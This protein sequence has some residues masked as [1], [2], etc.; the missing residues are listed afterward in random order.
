MRVW[1]SVRMSFLLLFSASSIGVLAGPA[2][3]F[4]FVVQVLKD[5]FTKVVLWEDKKTAL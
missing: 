2:L 1:M 4:L 5:V 3:L